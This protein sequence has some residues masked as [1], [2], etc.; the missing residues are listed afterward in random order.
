VWAAVDSLAW[1]GNAWADRTETDQ[2]GWPTR[3]PL[4]P[5]HVVEADPSSSGWKILGTRIPATDL[6]HMAMRAPAGERLGWGVMDTYQHELKIMRAVERAQMVVMRH[7]VPTGI[8]K[9]DPQMHMTREG[10]AEL[11]ADWMRKQQTRTVAALKGVDFQRVSFSADELSMI[12]TREF[13]LR[14]ASDITGVPPYLLGVPSESRVYANAETEWANFIRTTLEPF[15]VLI[16]YHLSRN[17]PRGQ[18]AAFDRTQLLRA[19][20][21]TRW[22]VHETAHRIGAMTVTEIRNAEDLPPLEGTENA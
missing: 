20:A 15:L 17:L 5:T 13:S 1:W 9:I 8:L 10:M 16:E 19:D 11:V 12:P 21:A 14:L 6:V 2:F 3:L 7:G 18:V 4:L 22:A